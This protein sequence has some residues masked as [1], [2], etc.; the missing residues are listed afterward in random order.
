MYLK[1][2]VSMWQGGWQHNS[3]SVILTL[4]WNKIYEIERPAVDI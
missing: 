2:A 4:S 3:K 1:R